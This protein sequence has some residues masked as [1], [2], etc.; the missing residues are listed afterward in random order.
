MIGLIDDN[1]LVISCSTESLVY[2]E[3]DTSITIGSSLMLSDLDIDH[4]IYNSTITITNPQNGDQLSSVDS[5]NSDL[6]VTPVNNGSS[7]LI[8][9]VS[10]ASVY[11][12]CSYSIIGVLIIIDCLLLGIT[13]I[14]FIFKQC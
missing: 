3:Q 10:T 6:T 2:T 5:V 12:V 9:G 14:H 13:A 1:D 4:Q 8:N 11:Q 7:I